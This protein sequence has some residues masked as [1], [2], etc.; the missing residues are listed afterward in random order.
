MSFEQTI[1][2]QIGYFAAMLYNPNNV[3]IEASP[4]TTRLELEVAAQLAAM[5]GYD[6]ATSWG[7]LASGG[8]VANLEA[9][10]IARNI[11]YLPIAASGAAGELGIGLGVAR[12]AA[13]RADLARLGLWELLNVRSDDVMDLWSML[14]RAGPADEVQRALDAHSLGAV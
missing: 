11:F 3:A 8:T 2:S 1:A 9:L 14:W 4:V 12:P 13:S 7:H 5:I 10:W 6:P